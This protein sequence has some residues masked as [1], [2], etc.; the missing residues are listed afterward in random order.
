MGKKRGKN[1]H[2]KICSVQQSATF[3]KK[4][5]GWRTICFV[6]ISNRKVYESTLHA[7][8]NGQEWMFHDNDKNGG[9]RTN[10]IL[11]TERNLNFRIIRRF[12]KETKHVE[13]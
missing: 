10:W 13:K 9:Q 6:P 5:I 7:F 12:E 1:R 3:K 4:V 11:N 2:D 8:L